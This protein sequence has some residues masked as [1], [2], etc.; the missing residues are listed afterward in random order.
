MTLRALALCLALP[1]SAW[2]QEPPLPAAADAV[3]RYPLRLAEPDFI[4]PGEPFKLVDL[5]YG[6]SDTFSTT[7]AFA[8][9]VR[10]RDWAYVGADLEGERRA[11]TVEAHRLFLA[12][13]GNDGEYDFLGRYRARRLIVTANAHR[14]SPARGAEWL[15]VPA[16][17]VRLTRDFELLGEVTH[18]TGIEGP[19]LRT[20]LAGFLWQRG[21]RFEASGEYAHALER[22]EEGSDNDRDVATLRVVG[23]VGPAELSGVALYEDVDGLFP[24][25]HVEGGLSARVS[26]AP[27][28]LLEGGG[29]TRFERH[30]NERAHEFRGAVTW[31]ARRFSLPRSGPGAGPTLL[32]ARRAT[33]MGYNERRVFG[34]DER[35]A[36]RE[37]LS[38]APRRE[39]LV[40]DMVG[41]YRAEIEERP[42]PTL[43]VEYVETDDALSG[44]TS[45]TARL[46]VGVP[47]RPSW[48]WRHDESA[49]PFLRLDVER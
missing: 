43:G 1:A 49:T 36:Q 35:R 15:L 47:W 2:S 19:F 16:L 46:R 12:A 18:E 6:F 26:L 4:A 20:W 44:F 39:E 27:R 41:L 48:P 40:G 23:Q 30:G 8:A 17:S 45:R 42:V 14:R 3:V 10:V 5:R 31:F 29:R 11:L 33:E 32:L 37:R 34:E 7:H 21:T 22:T 24:R 25:E 28:L 38:L 9:R 13:E